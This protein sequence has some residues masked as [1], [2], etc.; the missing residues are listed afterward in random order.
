MARARSV[1]S[2]LRCRGFGF[3]ALSKFGVGGGN[4]RVWDGQAGGVCCAWSAS[5]RGRAM[6][7]SRETVVNLLVPCAGGKWNGE[8]EKPRRPTGNPR[9]ECEIGGRYQ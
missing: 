8:R 9:G 4:G 1:D 5:G 2:D 3:C 7:S 6:S